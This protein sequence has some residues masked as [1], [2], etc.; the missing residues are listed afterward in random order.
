MALSPE[1]QN[2]RNKKI[3]DAYHC[4]VNIKTPKGN[5]LKT[6]KAIIEELSEEFNLSEFWINK[7]LVN[8]KRSK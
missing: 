6:K 8:N 7:I 1:R 3:I 2:K 4:A 5:Q